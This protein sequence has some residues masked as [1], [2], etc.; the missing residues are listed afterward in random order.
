MRLLNLVAQGFIGTEARWTLE[1]LL[2]A[3]EYV[4][5]ERRTF[6]GWN[7]HIEEG[8]HAASF[9]PCQPAPDG[10]ATHTKEARDVL[11][12]LRLLTRQQLEHLQ[13]WFLASIIFTLE[14]LLEFINAFANW[15]YIFVHGT[16]PWWV[17]YMVQG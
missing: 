6:A 2:D 7:I 11:A 13:P 5:C 10:I 14:A 8:H 3:G 15:R 9:V 16:R 17:P 4:G 12:R 1:R